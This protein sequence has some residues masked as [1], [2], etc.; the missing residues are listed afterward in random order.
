MRE[1]VRRTT[2]TPPPWAAGKSRGGGGEEEE[3]VAKVFGGLGFNV[4]GVEEI[5]IYIYI[6]GKITINYP[7]IYS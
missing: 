6:L 3:G 5:S 7:I 1:E 4:E 2:S